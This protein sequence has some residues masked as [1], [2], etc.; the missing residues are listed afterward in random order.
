[1]SNEEDAPLG[2]EPGVVS[3]NAISTTALEFCRKLI[4]YILESV[5]TT[6]HHLSDI[7]HVLIGVFRKRR[8]RGLVREAEAVIG[9]QIARV[10]LGESQLRDQLDAIDQR[11]ENLKSADASP[12]QLLTERK[13][14]LRRLFRDTDEIA[15]EPAF[16]VSARRSLDEILEMQEQNEESFGAA[17][18]RLV[19]STAGD[20]RK[21]GVGYAMICALVFLGA[22]VLLPSSSGPSQ[23]AITGI[24][25]RRIEES[26]GLVVSG[27]RLTMPDGEVDEFHTSTGTCFA[28][29][30]DGYLL[31][32]KHVTES[33]ENLQR[34]EAL[35]E[36][37]RKEALI[38]LSPQLW[39]FFAGE[40]YAAKV[41]YSDKKYD[42]AILKIEREHHPFLRLATPTETNRGTEVYALGF[43]GAASDVLSESE[44]LRKVEQKDKHMLIK[45]R[46][47]SDE[48]D[49][50]MTK[51]IVSRIVLRDEIEWI[52][53]NAAINFGNSGGP[54][55]TAE[56]RTVG[57]NTMGHVEA[58]G[59]FYS[60][61]MKQLIQ[62]LSEHGV[63]V[64]LGTSD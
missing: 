24:D 27:L 1:M 6:G 29:T 9:E 15:G 43:P 13:G 21:L 7:W 4:L 5:K 62:I 16:V 36:R 32:N 30:P 2:D 57:I 3:E 18:K 25:D 44:V 11:I 17:R 23:M 19:P 14:I 22:K 31:T 38:E 10:G 39:V 26:I 8:L 60:F 56:A 12:K 52:Q 53:H 48:F 64:D 46:F 51:G 63:E 35:R 20:W 55:I 45:Q 40:Q 49:Y 50:T 42:L 61:T 28:I 58:Q 34:A 33:Y 47:R 37:F 54:L 41:L 59:V